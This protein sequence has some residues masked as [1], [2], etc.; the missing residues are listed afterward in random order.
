[1][2]VIIVKIIKT[3]IILPVKRFLNCFECFSELVFLLCSPRTQ[4]SLLNAHLYVDLAKKTRHTHIIYN[5]VVKNS[6]TEG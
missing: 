6:F 3:K 1:M 5:G 4:L 2:S